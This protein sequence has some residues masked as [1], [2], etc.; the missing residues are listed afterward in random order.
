[1]LSI[2]IA[3]LLIVAVSVAILLF[4]AFPYRHRDLPG[5][6][7]LGRL[8]G[9]ALDASPHLRADEADALFA[10]PRSNADHT[11]MSHS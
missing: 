8:M 3:M 1:M 6:P 7:G 5:L 9:R 11:R 2:V 10:H 4:V